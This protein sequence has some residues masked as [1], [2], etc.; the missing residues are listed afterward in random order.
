MKVKQRIAS[1]DFN[2]LSPTILI[3]HN[4]YPNVNVGILSPPELDEKTWL[5]DAP[6][7]WAQNDFKIPEIVDF[8]SG[9]INSRFRQDVKMVMHRNKFLETVQEVAMASKPVDI[10][11]NLNEAPRFRLNVDTF[12][13]PS[14]PNARLK[15]IS[16]T[17]NPKIDTRVDRIVS[18]SDLK[19][20]NAMIALNKKGFDENFLTKLLSAATLGLKP[21]RKLV[22]TR[23]A[24]TAT[25]D[26]LAKN[27][28]AEIKDYPVADFL[29]YF[30]SYLGNY[31][32]IL[33]FPEVYSYEL[34]EIYAPKAEWNVSSEIQ[35]MTDYEPYALRKTYAENCGGGFYSVRLA[36]AEYLKKIKKQAS[37]LVLR[38][39][40][41]EYGIPLG[42]WVTREASR[43]SLASKPV[44]FGNKE[45]MLNYARL[46]AKKKFGMD[47]DS[48]LK[49][50]IM[51]NTMKNQ[52]KLSSWS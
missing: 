30:G 3:G 23:W 45:L 15:N 37:V 33:M 47:I 5:Y 36:I 42:V 20:R 46:L 51:L 40:T 4:F 16:I 29:A 13:A 41:E 48:I 24:I 18:D 34:F 35:Y 11:V 32:L 49:Q 19:A 2:A 44:E 27:L 21:Q 7:H 52:K 6:K 26:T 39:I 1:Q 38:F 43:K 31:Y 10:E 25:D 17:S 22:P 8:R 9:L 12:L 14:G 28:I 50:S